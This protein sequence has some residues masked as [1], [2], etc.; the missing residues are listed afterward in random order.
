MLKIF[1]GAVATGEPC[2]QAADEGNP[3]SRPLLKLDRRERSA[4]YSTTLLPLEKEAVAIALKPKS[5]KA[6]R[7]RDT[8]SAPTRVICD[9]LVIVL[10]VCTGAFVFGAELFQPRCG[11]R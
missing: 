10:H 2:K 9:E 1:L 11:Q 6:C 4:S 5:N 3:S 7:V 8:V